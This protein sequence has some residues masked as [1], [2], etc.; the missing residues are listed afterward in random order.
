M[1]LIDEPHA[2][3]AVPYSKPAKCSYSSDGMAEVFIQGG[4]KP[5]SYLWYDGQSDSVAY[6][7]AGN[8][9]VTVL[10][11]NNCRITQ[12]FTIEAPE[13]L[14]SD[15]VSSRTICRGQSTILKTEATNGTYPYDFFWSDNK[16]NT[17]NA[18]IW[19]VSP[20]STTIYSV[21]VV[22][23]HHCS[24]S[25]DNIIVEVLSPIRIESIITDE[26]TVCPG[27]ETEIRVQVTGGNGGPYM[28][29]LQDGTIVGSPFVVKP[30]VTT[31]YYITVDDLC[32]SQPVTGMITIYVQS[33]L[34]VMFTADV[35]QDCAPMTV[36][37]TNQIDSIDVED[38]DV[39]NLDYAWR[40]GD[41]GSATGQTA[42]HTYMQD[43][44]YD[45]TLIVTDAFGCSHTLTIQNM[46]E[47]YPIPFATFAFTPE[48]AT[49][50]TP[51][52]TFINHST[53]ATNFY[54]NFDDGNVSNHEHVL[55]NFAPSLSPYNVCLVAEN[56]YG[57]RDTVCREV[58]VED[59]P[60]L[61]FPN[62]FTPDGDGINDCFKPC[63]NFISN[64]DYKLTIID[65]WGEVVYETTDYDPTETATD[66]SECSENS[67]NGKMKNKGQTLPNGVYI[68]H[69]T[70]KDKHGIWY[71][72]DG[73]VTLLR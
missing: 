17:W 8:F 55:H 14:I 18:N 3:S 57:C 50:A 36:T 28:M 52:I 25:Q 27:I 19:Q 26:Q 16:G 15:H 33:N 13:P 56:I 43:G 30:L 66:R 38:I 62:S 6:L 73:Q 21:T 35:L 10:D 45:V 20:D 42:S 71:E 70:Y 12:S 44:S 34:P 29:R 67:W 23:A 54:W 46:I 4:V 59:I 49:E 7:P 22:D 39:E 72:R 41:E 24:V 68:W 61:Y 65:K 11:A 53:G 32:T 64:D 9:E 47:V 1:F 63:G 37:F 40:F 5:Y 48:F 60:V 31:T 51:E 69:C 58:A 2:L